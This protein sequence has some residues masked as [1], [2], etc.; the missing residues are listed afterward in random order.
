MTIDAVE[1]YVGLG[2]TVLWPVQGLDYGE[3]AVAR[4]ADIEGGQGFWGRFDAALEQESATAP[5]WWELCTSG[6]RKDDF[7]H[8]LVVLSEIE[9][10]LPGASIYVSAQ[11]DYA[12]G[13]VCTLAGPQGP[14]LMQDL[15]TELVETG[16]VLAGPTLSALQPQQLVDTC[17]AGRDGKQQMG[18]ELLNFFGR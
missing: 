1:G 15:A 6:S 10:N 3:G 17:H 2:G 16:R 4:W 8:A 11:P 12:G 18:R 7:D 9:E 14:S 5:V 13:H